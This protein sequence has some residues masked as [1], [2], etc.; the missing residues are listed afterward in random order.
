[1]QKFNGGGVYIKYLFALLLILPNILWGTCDSSLNP[2]TTNTS[3]TPVIINEL[4]TI[5]SISKCISGS[6]NPDNKKDYYSFTVKTSGTLT[7]DTSHTTS[8]KYLILSLYKKNADPT[9]FYGKTKSNHPQQKITLE[10]NEKFII[11]FGSYEEGTSNYEATFDFVADNRVPIIETIPEMNII[12]GENISPYQVIATDT[13][14]DALTYSITGDSYG[15]SIDSS[16][17]EITGISTINAGE[18]QNIT[19]SITDGTETVTSSFDIKAENNSPIMEDILDMN[20]TLG[21]SFSY[22]VLASD[23]DYGDTITYAIA[24]SETYGL[25]I[26]SSTGLIT[27]TPTTRVNNTIEIRVTDNSGLFIQNNFRFKVIQ[28][29]PTITVI[30]DQTMTRYQEFSSNLSTFV[31]KTEED[32]ILSYNL[33]GTPPSGITLNST[34]GILSGISTNIGTFPVTL[35]ATD[36]DGISNAQSFN[37]ISTDGTDNLKNGLNAKYYDNVTWNGDANI[38]RIDANVDFDWGSNN[39]SGGLDD[40]QF[41]VK[42]TG[43]IYLPED[44]EYGFILDITDGDVILNIDNKKSYISGKKYNGTSSLYVEKANYTTGYYPIEISFKNGTS[45][46]KGIHLKWDNNVTISSEVVPTTNLFPTEPS[47]TFEEN[48]DDICYEEFEFIGTMCIDMG[49]CKGGIGCKTSIPLNNKGDSTIEQVKLYYDET[50]IGGTMGDDCAVEPSGT[51][52]T[53]NNIDM[54]SMG[55]L[56]STT[57]FEFENSIAPIDTN[58]KISTTASVSMSCLNTSGLYATY[59]KGSLNYRGKVVA[60]NSTTNNEL[61]NEAIPTDSDNIFLETCGTF[62]DALQTRANDSSVDFSSGSAKVYNNP[63]NTLNTYLTPVNGDPENNITCNDTAGTS[64]DNSSCIPSNKGAESFDD[65]IGGMK[66]PASFTIALPVSTSTTNI[67]A[68]GEELIDGNYNTIT[69]SGSTNIP[70]EITTSVAVNELKNGASNGSVTFKSSSNIEYQFSINSIKTKENAEFKT[71]DDKTKNIKIGTISQYDTS[72]EG[73]ANITVD[74][75][76]IQTIKIENLYIGHSSNYKLRAPYININNIKDI[77]GVGQE[78]IIHIIADYV[79]IGSFELGDATTLIIEPYTVGKKVIVKMNQFSTGSNNQIEF[80]SGIYYIKT[81]TTSGS[82]AGYKWDVNGKVDLIIEEDYEMISEIGINSDTTGSDNLCSDS[83]SVLDLFIFTYGN[84]TVNNNSRIVG[85][86]YSKQDV[87]LG[88]ASYIKGGISAENTIVLGDA[89]EVCYDSDLIDSGY[90]DCNTTGDEEEPEISQCG[91]FPSALQTYQNLTLNGGG[92]NEVIVVNVENI[93]A[94]HEKVIP[95]VD[96]DE[97]GSIITNDALCDNKPCE[98]LPPNIIDYSVPFKVTQDLSSISITSDIILSKKEVG[99]YRADQKDITIK[100]NATESYDSARKYMMIGDLN[101]ANKTGIKYVFTDGDYYIKSWTHQGNDLTIEAIGKVRIFLKGKLNWQGNTLTIN[102]GGTASNFF[103]FGQDDFLFSN[104]GLSHTDVTAFFYSKGAVNIKSNSNSGDGF[105]GGI[106]AEGDLSLNNNA[107]FRYDPTGLDANGMGVCGTLVQ[108]SATEYRFK[109]PAIDSGLADTTYQEVNIT[110]SEALSYPVIVKYETFDGN[111]TTDARKV[112]DYTE[113]EL[114]PQEVTIPAGQTFVLVDTIINRDNYIESDEKFY[115]KIELITQGEDVILGGRIEATLIISAQTE[116]DIPLCFE[117]NFDSALSDKWRTLFASGGFE[118]EIVDGRLRLTDR[119]KNR[120]TAVTKDYYFV[121]KQNLIEIEFLHYAYGGCE[122]G[123]GEGAYGA[124]GV[125]MVLFDSDVGL[126]P[127]PGAYGGSLGYAQMKVYSSSIKEEGFEGGWLGMAIDEYGNFANPDEGREGGAYEKIGYTYSDGIAIRGSSG[128]LSSS[129]R[130]T[131][132]KYLGGTRSLKKAI[133]TKDNSSPYPGDK[134]KLRVDAR[135]SD[136]LLVSLQQETNSD[137]G[138]KTIIPEFDVKG[139]LYQ[140]AE[141]PDFVRLA[142]TSGTGGGCNNHEIDDLTV[143][144]VCRVYNTDLYNKG[145]FSA[146][147]K[148]KTTIADKILRTKV[149]SEQFT[150]K[151]A[152]LTP[153]RDEL[154][155]KQRKSIIEIDPD[156]SISCSAETMPINKR[157]YCNYLQAAARLSE[158]NIDDITKLDIKVKYELVDSSD[159]TSADVIT[160][161]VDNGDD[162]MFNATKQDSAFKNFKVDRAYTEVK[163]RFRICADYNVENEKYSVF[164]YEACAEDVP[165]REPPIGNELGYRLIYSDDNFAIRPD[166]FSSNI[167]RSYIAQEPFEMRFDALSGSN[168]ATYGYNEKQDN[169][170]TV[171]IINQDRDCEVKDLE[172]D[173]KVSFKNGT[174]TNNY[175]LSNLGTYDLEINEIEGKEFAIIDAN[176]TDDSQRY[177]TKLIEEDIKVKPSAFKLNGIKLNNFN[178]NEYTHLSDLTLDQTMASTLDFSIT[179]VRADDSIDPNYSGTCSAQNTKADITFE[180]TEIQPPNTTDSLKYTNNGEINEVKKDSTDSIIHLKYDI[181]REEFREG[182]A[183]INIPFNFTKN[184]LTPSNPFNLNISDIDVKENI[185]SNPLSISA[186]TVDTQKSYSTQNT[187][188]LYSR[189]RASKKVYPGVKESSQG[190]PIL[191]DVYCLQSGFSSD[192]TC[193]DFN[194]DIENNGIIENTWFINTRFDSSSKREGYIETQ[195]TKGEASVSNINIRSKG[196]DDSV[197][198]T[199]ESEEEQIVEIQIQPS[200]WL[201]HDETDNMGYPSYEVEF[202]IGMA[203]VAENWSGVG[204]KGHTLD[205]NGSGAQQRQRMNW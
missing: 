37:I 205:T 29:P 3:S 184:L 1:M 145:P 202:L 158:Q 19:V 44:G 185:S 20:I 106:T 105:I 112:Y 17:G 121:T 183:T 182:I 67:T 138:Y 56:G 84:F 4:N 90:A 38:S 149:A 164:P 203:E 176:D 173:P 143:K 192:I 142:F 126:S 170:F 91:I 178:N 130:Y 169:S 199:S 10:S 9:W 54:G 63:D 131:G 148:D 124:D 127:E 111:E 42:W 47:T 137:E 140:Q 190:T 81:L 132:Y 58:A 33:N 50:G 93:V 165:Y 204:E 175:K 110:L 174:V 119:G 123:G 65:P 60:C 171:S 27:G 76:A 7:I 14:E 39:P 103:V 94:P 92:G 162:N 117:D 197:T 61:V 99:S 200:A 180:T 133:A 166:K 35:T 135:D 16:T 12:S 172:L 159:M 89:T 122:N 118:P 87:T 2:T 46:T 194:L 120:S 144:G 193:D 49:V 107:K 177:I 147:D 30:P 116:D 191:T 80:Y 109:E 97:N 198:V 48:A 104:T 69:S 79:D 51:C 25:S 115:A 157:A 102:K 128:D 22:Q 108:F 153:E 62:D 13:D 74:F 52:D 189:V 163:M 78:N 24:Q 188:F 71:I 134:Y 77:S 160:S 68:N 141:L 34:T 181:A 168:K 5:T 55:I 32:N 8:N 26:D 154:E 187:T 23:P 64:G 36:R 129:T 43:W 179:A 15:L 152:S 31:T 28:T 11:K 146:W 161:T 57:E 113:N 150:L 136:Q 114:N 167:G 201:R 155:I 40:D 53:S 88:G 70:F 21:E 95:L 196:E 83:H 151:I 72:T 125:V 100:F 75:K 98:V 73:S 45:T 59:V 6:V 66:S 82:G 139:D 86:V 101:S 18:T 85:T 156:A 96:I 186:S 41:S 195:I